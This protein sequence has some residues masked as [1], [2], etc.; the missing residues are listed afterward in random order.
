ME[1]AWG[2]D[3]NK[4]LQNWCGGGGIYLDCICFVDTQEEGASAQV[5]QPR[6]WISKEVL[7]SGGLTWK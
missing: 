6:G 7:C 3:Q 4:N 5:A 1:R 2:G